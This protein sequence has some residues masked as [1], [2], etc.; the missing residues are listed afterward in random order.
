MSAQTL[1]KVADIPSAIYDVLYNIKLGIINSRN[2]VV[3]AL[4]Q[5]ISFDMDVIVSEG[6]NAIAKT[7]VT[8]SLPD[9]TTESTPDVTTTDSIG[10][11]LEVSSEVGISTE[12]G[13]ES[14]GEGSASG[15]NQVGTQQ[16]SSNDYTTTDYY[17]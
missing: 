14:G 10:G 15:E 7:V 4:P 6:V 3:I 8:S 5:E 16:S 17:I 12:S 2:Q 9:V 1:V 11:S 13:S